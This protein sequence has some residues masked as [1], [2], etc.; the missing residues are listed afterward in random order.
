MGVAYFPRRA[1]SVGGAM[2]QI[3][4]TTRCEGFKFC[5]ENVRA[6]FTCGRFIK[7]TVKSISY[8]LQDKYDAALFYEVKIVSKGQEQAPECIKNFLS[9]SKYINQARTPKILNWSISL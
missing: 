8:L 2:D 7:I 6:Y 5:M 4:C 1:S 9:C 3:T